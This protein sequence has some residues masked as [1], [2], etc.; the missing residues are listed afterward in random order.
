ML[1]SLLKMTIVCVFNKFILL[2]DLLATSTGDF[3]E[4][5]LNL[6][7]FHTITYKPYNMVY[8]ILNSSKTSTYIILCQDASTA[9]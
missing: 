3:S 9:L 1:L 7:L 8:C 4:Y 5:R 2:R 6:N